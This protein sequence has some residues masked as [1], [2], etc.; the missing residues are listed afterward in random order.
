MTGNLS[1]Q[2]KANCTLSSFW[3]NE[4]GSNSWPSRLCGAGVLPDYCPMMTF[5]WAT[6]CHWTRKSVATCAT[7]C[8]WMKRHCV[9]VMLLE[10]EYLLWLLMMVRKV[11]HNT[12]KL[13][14]LNPGSSSTDLGMRSVVCLL[15]SEFQIS[16]FSS[17]SLALSGSSL[18]DE[19]FVQLVFIKCIK[20]IPCIPSS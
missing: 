15:S 19:G 9:L 2:A 3:A 5:H 10:G 14:Q 16:V 20:N 1:A 11:Q 6:F 7:V 13:L 8:I 12:V 18:V 17:C 4:W